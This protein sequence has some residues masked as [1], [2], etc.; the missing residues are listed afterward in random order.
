MFQYFV[1]EA[2]KSQESESQSEAEDLSQHHQH[3]VT[4]ESENLEEICQQTDD[5]KPTESIDSNVEKEQQSSPV[6]PKDRPEYN[7]ET[8]EDTEDEGGNYESGSARPNAT[9]GVR[10]GGSIEAMEKC[11]DKEPVASDGNTSS[12]CD[13]AGEIA[14]ISEVKM[15]QD[16]VCEKVDEN[17]STSLTSFEA[18][19]SDETPLNDTDAGETKPIEDE[20]SKVEIKTQDEADLSEADG[21][22]GVA[23][24]DSTLTNNNKPEDENCPEEEIA[25]SNNDAK[26]EPSESKEV[27][28]EETLKDD[29]KDVK[30]EEATTTIIPD[31]SCTEELSES[32]VQSEIQ[33]NEED[34][35]EKMEESDSRCV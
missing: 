24:A 16:E 17:V 29:S 13:N 26:D 19:A 5:D 8:D 21:L 4:Q 30:E 10:E 32:N 25:E 20:T 11:V 12:A 23:N 15:S 27:E 28:T 35:E 9:E 33:V 34:S 22:Q 7:S 3:N 14:D 2:Y 1:E 18:G 31:S 6:T